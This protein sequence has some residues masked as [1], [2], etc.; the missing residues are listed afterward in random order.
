[1][2]LYEK[3]YNKYKQKYLKLK[4]QLGGGGNIEKNSIDMVSMVSEANI[5]IN[6][7]TEIVKKLLSQL[8]QNTKKLKEQLGSGENIEKNPIDM[9]SEANIS[10]NNNTEIVKE[11]LSQLR[12]NT[13]NRIQLKYEESDKE[14]DEY[15]TEAE[16]TECADFANI[17]VPK[18]PEALCQN[19]FNKDKLKESIGPTELGELKSEYKTIF[20]NLAMQVHPDKN[21]NCVK[22]ANR[23]FNLLNEVREKCDKIAGNIQTTK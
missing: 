4:E 19:L 13:K 11:L 16:K 21:P 12:Q 9:V 8:G 23:K 7:N 14:S 22:I 18:K 20:R 1:M 2:S 6:N 10:I 17:E 3:K 15:K 5:S